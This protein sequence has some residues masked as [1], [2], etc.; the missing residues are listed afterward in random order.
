[1]S[2]VFYLVNLLGGEAFEVVTTVPDKASADAY[3]MR[4]A[5][6]GAFWHNTKDV[7]GPATHKFDEQRLS[8]ETKALSREPAGSEVLRLLI[9]KGILTRDDVAAMDDMVAARVD[10][11][12]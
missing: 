1:M 9:N 8:F 3:D 2:E 7:F 5:P 11:K 10:V 4:T 6:K 12:Q